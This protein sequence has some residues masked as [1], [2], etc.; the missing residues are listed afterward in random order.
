LGVQVV[1]TLRL[2]AGVPEGTP[3]I[4]MSRMNASKSCRLT[5]RMDL[6]GALL[7]LFG[8]G[9]VGAALVNV[10]SALLSRITW[11]DSREEPFSALT[12]WPATVVWPMP[13]MEAP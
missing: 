3:R 12:A 1:S 10:L 9:H 6:A 2:Q 4:I 11:V 8:A 13:D 7:W 5:E